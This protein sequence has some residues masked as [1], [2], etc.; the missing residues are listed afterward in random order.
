MTPVYI[1][2]SQIEALHPCED[3][4]REVRRFFGERQRIRVT[5]KVAVAVAV[6]QRFNFCWLARHTLRG[7]ARDTYSILTRT[8]YAALG[9]AVA[10]ALAKKRASRASLTA[11]FD[12]AAVEARDVA[13]RA[14]LPFDDLLSPAYA[15]LDIGR[16]AAQQECDADVAAAQRN[17]DVD[18]AAAWAREYVNQERQS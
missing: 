9:C 14:A 11:E 3:A 5:V 10:R 1:T 8:T 2:L 15:A 12:R 4:L 6:A 16:F 13:N 7:D 18:I 17:F